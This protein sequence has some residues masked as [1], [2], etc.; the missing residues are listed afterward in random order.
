MPKADKETAK[1]QEQLKPVADWVNSEGYKRFKKK[2]MM[3]LV[4][5][6]SLLHLKV[7][8]N[9]D[10]RAVAADY[11]ARQLLGHMLIETLQELEGDAA[12]YKAN[13][14]MLTESEVEEMF[15][16]LPDERSEE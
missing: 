9:A 2:L 14:E 10:P 6:T 1:I 8:P 12:Q 13:E 4:E 5:Q 11:G 16:R 7:L 3:K 15:A